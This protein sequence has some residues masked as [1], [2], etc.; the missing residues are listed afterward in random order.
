MTGHRHDPDVRGE[1][2]HVHTDRGAHGVAPGSRPV[3]LSVPALTCTGAPQF[4]DP[5]AD[6]VPKLT[7]VP[8]AAGCFRTS[9]AESGR[10]DSPKNHEAVSPACSAGRGPG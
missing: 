10:I 5:S 8:E 9:V 6:T 2:A 3:T 1:R 7:S 4:V